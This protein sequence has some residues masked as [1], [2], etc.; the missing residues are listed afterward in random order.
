MGSGVKRF[1]LPQGTAAWSWRRFYDRD[2]ALTF[3]ARLSADHPPPIH[4]AE[5]QL[6]PD[7]TVLPAGAWV[8]IYRPIIV[9]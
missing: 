6:A 2:E 3:H 9:D 4:L 5:A 7:G 8:V 1:T